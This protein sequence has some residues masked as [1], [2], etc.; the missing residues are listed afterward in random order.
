MA[1]SLGAVLL[2]VDEARDIEPTQFSLWGLGSGIYFGRHHRSLLQ[3]VDSWK[4]GPASAFLFATAG[5]SF[6]SP[7]QHWALRRRLKRKGTHILGEFCCR[8]WDTVGPLWLM[9]GLNRRRP[10]ASDLQRAREFARQFQER[11]SHP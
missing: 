1:E 4:Q 2:T 9:G 8:G 3:L 11:P 6:L 7:V 5:L 10:N